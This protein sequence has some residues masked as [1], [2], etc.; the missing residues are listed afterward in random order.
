VARSAAPA[1][2]DE[3]SKD[4][5]IR[6]DQANTIARR[7]TEGGANWPT[8]ARAM[9]EIKTSFAE[10]ALDAVKMHQVDKASRF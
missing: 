10:R 2:L 8:K 1:V 4:R 3:I 5:G 7:Y 6:K 9:K